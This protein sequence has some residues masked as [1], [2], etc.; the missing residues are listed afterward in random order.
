[1]EK[2]TPSRRAIAWR[3]S[4]TALTALALAAVLA[5]PARAAD[6]EITIENF[7]FSPQALTVKAGT[8]VLF[9][10]GDDIPHSVAATN[11]AF[12][13]QALDTGESFSFTF[14]EPGTYDYFCGLHP[15][16][17]GH[18]VVIP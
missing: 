1:M 8:A 15:Q 11:G 9:R 17:K 10:N 12:H 5:W 7:T 14:A 6:S 3:H 4:R 16:M 13:S 18:I 2:W